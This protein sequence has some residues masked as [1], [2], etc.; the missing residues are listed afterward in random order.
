M[1]G[2]ERF[3]YAAR[4]LLYDCQRSLQYAPSGAIVLLQEDLM[5]VL[6]V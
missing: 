6:K 1:A 3:L 4:I 5:C 2:F